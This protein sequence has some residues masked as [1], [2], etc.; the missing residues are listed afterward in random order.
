MMP[1]PV[2]KKSS[3]A[4]LWAE[5]CAAREEIESQQRKIIRQSVAMKN[6]NDSMEAMRCQ[7]ISATL[8]INVIRAAVTIPEKVA[9]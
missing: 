2:T 5:L 4:A 1:K 7:L 9:I 6:M 3:R 8:Q